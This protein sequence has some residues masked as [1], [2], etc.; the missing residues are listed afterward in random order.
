ME[1]E[2]STVS[3][4]S[5]RPQRSCQIIRA[6]EEQWTLFCLWSQTLVLLVSHLL[7]P[8]VLHFWPFSSWTSSIFHWLRSLLFIVPC[9]SFQTIPL[10]L[11]QEVL[12]LLA[13]PGLCPLSRKLVPL[14]DGRLT[15]QSC[16]QHLTHR[17]PLLCSQDSP[18]SPLW[19]LPSTIPLTDEGLDILRWRWAFC[20]S[21]RED[22]LTV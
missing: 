20:P 14:Q 19:L 11:A 2:S 5:R 10:V 21:N 7:G 17:P 1:T 4:T 16:P 9:T 12:W 8:R 15:T 22:S 6:S 13:S 18:L 3:P